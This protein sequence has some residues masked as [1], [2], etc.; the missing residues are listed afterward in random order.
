MAIGQLVIPKAQLG[1][2]AASSCSSRSL[3]ALCVVI[4]CVVECAAQTPRRGAV[5]R[6]RLQ[7]RL[8][9]ES[10]RGGCCTIRL[11]GEMPRA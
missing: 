8:Q 9:L 5:G 7:P 2:L 11:S 10:R 6:S 3:L 4:E 1:D